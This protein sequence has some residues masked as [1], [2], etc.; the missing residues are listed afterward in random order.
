L[1]GCVE[2][3]PSTLLYQGAN[4]AVKMAMFMS[5]FNSHL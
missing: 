3:G 4:K 5:L 1:S 2:K